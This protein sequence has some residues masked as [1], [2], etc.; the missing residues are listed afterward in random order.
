VA[1]MGQMGE[2]EDRGSPEHLHGSAHMREKAEEEEWC[3]AASYWGRGEIGAGLGVWTRREWR[4]AWS[5]RGA[6]GGVA[7]ARAAGGPR[8]SGMAQQCDGGGRR[9]HDACMVHCQWEGGGRAR[10]RRK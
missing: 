6:R 9:G 1:G 7:L 4:G 10:P 3:L 2:A 5:Q 8:A